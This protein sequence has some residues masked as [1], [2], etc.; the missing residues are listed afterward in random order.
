MAA[1]AHIESSMQGDEPTCF[2]DAG[3]TAL[4]ATPVILGASRFGRCRLAGI[5]P[6]FG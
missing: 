5:A 4:E 3:T 6:L 1:A 2:A